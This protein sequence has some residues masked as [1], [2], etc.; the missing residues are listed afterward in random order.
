MGLIDSINRPGK[1]SF[2][3]FWGLVI[4]ATWVLMWALF[5]I[6]EYGR[7]QASM[8]PYQVFMLVSVVPLAVVTFVVQTVL[9]FMGRKVWPVDFYKRK[10]LLFI[11]TPLIS[12]FCLWLALAMVGGVNYFLVII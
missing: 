9:F 2:L 7:L 1:R 4:V 5:M 6:F 10:R 12:W 8:V 11:G 3:L